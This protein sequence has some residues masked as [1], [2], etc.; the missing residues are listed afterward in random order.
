MT[1][2]NFQQFALSRAEIK[3]IVGGYDESGKKCSGTCSVRNEAG[4]VVSV[5]CITHKVNGSKVCSCGSASYV[6]SGCAWSS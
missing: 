4:N 2:S 1:I 3:R 5:D 6:K